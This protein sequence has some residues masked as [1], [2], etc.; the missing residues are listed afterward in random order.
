MRPTEDLNVRSITPIIAPEDLKQVFPAP[1]G[2]FELIAKSRER[3]V[4]IVT[5]RVEM[6]ERL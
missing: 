2:A 3:L 6:T 1:D 5:N 4:E